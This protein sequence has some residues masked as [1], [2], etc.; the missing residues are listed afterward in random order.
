MEKVW[1]S[2]DNKGVTFY[3]PLQIPEG[4]FVLGHYGCPNAQRPLKSPFFL[5]SITQDRSNMKGEIILAGPPLEEPSDYNLV[6]SS[7]EGQVYFWVPQAPEGYKALGCV[8]TNTPAKPTSKELVMCVRSDLTD[9]CQTEGAIWS[10]KS[11]TAWNIRPKVRGTKAAGVYVGTFY[12]QTGGLTP[13]DPLPIACLKNCNLDKFTA[14]PNVDQIN[15]LLY[16]YGPTV[17]FHPYEKY[18]PSSVDWFFQNGALLY[19]K[20]S[21][22]GAQPIEANGSNLPQGGDPD[23]G[24]YWLDLPKDGAAATRVKQGDLQSAEAYVHIKPMLG[25]TCSDIEM[26]LFY[27]FNG[28]RSLKVQLFHNISLGRIG[29]HGGDWEHFTLRINNLTGK[30]WRVYLSQHSS[31]QW[32]DTSELEYSEGSSDRAVIYSSKDG[33]ASYPEEGDFLQG[34]TKLQIGLRN[35]TKRSKYVL[36]TSMQFQIISA[37]YMQPQPLQEPPWLQYMRNWG[38]TVVYD[39]RAELDR[40]L[41]ILPSKLRHSVEDFFNKDIP[42]E[43]SSEKGPTGPKAKESWEGDEKEKA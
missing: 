2:P 25:G 32:L 8:V 15:E 12:C 1:S 13:N 19:S 29:Q 28:P 5:V 35:D 16:K 34:N 3:K 20:G 9:T 36:D 17:F 18:M 11:F 42:E 7:N 10:N 4:F 23:D 38:P 14:M 27:P 21:A 6:W 41:K 39:T 33:H 22:V 43:L 30:L 40:A 31:G 37:D 26:W 24:S